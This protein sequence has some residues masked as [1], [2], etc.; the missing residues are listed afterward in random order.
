MLNSCLDRGIHSDL[1][2]KLSHC[3]LPDIFFLVCV[4]SQFMDSFHYSY[5]DVVVT[6]CHMLSSLQAKDYFSSSEAMSRSLDIEMLFE[7]PPS[8]KCSTPGYC[9]F[10]GGNLMF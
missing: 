9:V 3:D 2:I 8:D 1:Y 6:F 7:G 5:W 4:V 10:V